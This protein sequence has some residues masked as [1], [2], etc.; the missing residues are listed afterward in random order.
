MPADSYSAILGWLNQ[1]TGNNNNQW[2]DN[3]DTAIFPVFERGIAGRLSS[4]VTGGTLTL[5]DTVPPTAMT[6]AVD[7]I[8]EFTGTLGSNQIVQVPNLSKTWL[9]H[10]QCTL[11][12]FTLKFKT[13]GGTASDAIPVGM[14]EVKC[15]GSNNIKVGLSTALRDVQWLG[16]DGTVSLPGISAAAEPSSG[17]FRNGAG[18]WRAAILGSSIFKWTASGIDLL[19]GNYKRAGTSLLPIGM[20]VDFPGITAPNGWALE[21]GQALSRTTYADLFEALSITATATRNGTTGLTSVS[22]DLRNLGLIG[23][24]IEGTGIA[25]GTTITAI[26][27]ATTITMSAAATGSGSMTIRALPHGQGDASTDFNIPDAQGR[28][29]A[30]RDDMSGTSANRLTD[31]TGGV[32]GDKLSDTGG[33]ETHTLT[34]AELAAHDHGGTTGA[35][36]AHTHTIN[37]GITGAVGGSN[38]NAISA[39]GEGQAQTSG[40]SDAGTSHTHSIASAGSDSAHNNV[41][42]TRITNKIIFTG[43]YT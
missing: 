30:G 29:T 6:E 23:A 38:F 20:E 13:S 39:L 16:A 21:Y 41:Q 1:G 11:A 24:Y 33:A 18:D 35:E 2:G 34:L 32:D 10:N 31:Q 8:Q 37:Y 28:V 22:V 36:A 9:V 12:G 40:A 3:C 5:D 17:I 25:T 19:A 26:P 42:P 27:T 4:A 7:Y 43:V 15:D 14:C